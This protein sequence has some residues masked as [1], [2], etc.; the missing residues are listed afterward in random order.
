[1]RL[2]AAISIPDA[3]K[4]ACE[5]RTTWQSELVRYALH[6]L[7]HLRGFDDLEPAPRR[8]MKCEEERLLKLVRARFPLRQLARPAKAKTG[9]RTSS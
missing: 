6:G 9:A 2:F 5:F 1:M 4:Q 8:R 7:L 3:V